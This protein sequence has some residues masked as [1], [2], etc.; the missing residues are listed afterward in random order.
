VSSEREPKQ[1]TNTTTTKLCVGL[2]PRFSVCITTYQARKTIK[3]SFE[4]LFSQ[5]DS[6][7]EV[8]V[9]D[10]SSTDGTIEYLKELESSGHIRLV[11]RKCT[12]G[13]GRQLAAESAQGE[14]L[15]QQ[16]DADQVYLP[17]FERAAERYEVEAGKDPDVLVIFWQKEPHSLLERIPSAISFVRKQSFL[18]KTKWP[19]VNYGE[20][21]H[22]FDVFAREGRLV[23][24]EESNYAEQLTGGLFETLRGALSN[25][26][27]LMDSGF[28][29]PW[30]L[31]TTRHRGLLFLGRALM[32]SLA[33]IWH[34]L[35]Q[36]GSH[37]SR[38]PGT[39]SGMP[40]P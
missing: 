8:V 14:V 11:V 9:V 30:V 37:R 27:E 6:R 21:Q 5:L 1:I 17:F 23:R 31:R 4:S 39:K 7:F 38:S 15:V 35:D 24:V 32:V 13:E 16:V 40:F 2:V 10:N 19:L 12:R 29:F 26:K 18:S 36:I 34:S 22:V 33:W 20:D 3:D 25:Q 28:S